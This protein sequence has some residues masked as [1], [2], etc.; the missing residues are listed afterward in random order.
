[1]VFDDKGGPN[2]AGK[3]AG[4]ELGHPLFLLHLQGPDMEKLFGAG[5][6]ETLQLLPRLGSNVH[7][8]CNPPAGLSCRE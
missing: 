1:M 8:A 3:E 7:V 5:S 6:E 2:P 4:W